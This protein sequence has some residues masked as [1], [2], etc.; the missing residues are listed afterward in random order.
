MTDGEDTYY[1]VYCKPA[2]EYMELHHT[3]KLP[4]YFVGS[5]DIDW[6]ERVTTQAI[7]QRHVDTAISSTVNLPKSAT[8]EDVAKMYLR[9]DLGVKALRCSVTDASVLAF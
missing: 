5:A 3:D 9:G 7:M 1:D 2:R 6:R 8:K 4:D